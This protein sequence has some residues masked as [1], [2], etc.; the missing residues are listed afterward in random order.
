[1]KIFISSVLVL[2]CLG[3]IIGGYSYEIPY[4]SNTFDMKYLFFRALILGAIVGIGLGWFFSK[5][6]TDASD[7]VP[8]F[9]LCLVGCLVV[10][11]LKASFINHF[12]A[13]ND[14][15]PTSSGSAIS[16]KVVFEKEEPLRTSRFGI[17]KNSV[18]TADAFYVHF[19]KDRK[20]DRIRSKTQNFRT[21]EKGQEIELPIKK[22]FFGF[23]FVDI[24]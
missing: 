11:P 14:P 17:A 21:V 24:N 2:L 22:G 18:L 16:T 19:I 8:I 15:L 9:M 23:E 10:F 12:F 7:R 20:M 3:G 6:M 13:K 5:K 1:M 4:F